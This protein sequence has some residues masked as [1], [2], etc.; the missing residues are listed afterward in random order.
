MCVSRWHFTDSM[1]DSVFI[2]IVKEIVAH[3][4]L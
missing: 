3:N 1:T 2:R 4:D